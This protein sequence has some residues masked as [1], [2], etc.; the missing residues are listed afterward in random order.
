MKVGVLFV[1]LVFLGGFAHA[2][3][4]VPDSGESLPDVPW[5]FELD[6][7]NQT[8]PDYLA[9]PRRMRLGISAAYFDSE[10]P[11]TSSGRAMLDAGTRF[12]LF[13]VRPDPESESEFSL[14]ILGGVFMQFDLG[15][16]LDNIGWDGVYGLNVVY[17]PEERLA[18]RL[19]YRHLSA[20]I[21]DEYIERTGRERISYTRD[22]LTFGVS[23]Q[24]AENWLAFVE[25]RWAF[26]MGDA[27]GME[28]GAV[29]AGFQYESPKHLGKGNASL[30]GGVHVQAY[31]ES[32]WKPGVSVQGG[33][34]FQRGDD[35]ANIRIGLEAYTGRAILG[36]Y[37]LEFDES[38]LLCGFMLDFY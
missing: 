10:I 1:F 3:E 13:R 15:N 4:D 18:F 5:A 26:N 29:E 23:Y 12:T 33:L 25:P 38:Y 14:D 21:G 22:D 17:S 19:G 27:D 36:E 34:H 37:A 7:D 31:Q 28:E 20:H 2:S 9:D 8:Y 32:D 11:E 16:Q 30:Y 6:P 24:F 35:G